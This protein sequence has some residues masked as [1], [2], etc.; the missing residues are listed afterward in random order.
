MKQKGFTVWFTG[1]SDA[2]KSTL[3][4]MLSQRLL[5]RGLK[6]QLLDGGVI[7]ATLN[8]HLEFT[9]EDRDTNVRC[10]GS[11]C[12]A[13]SKNGTVAIA[14]AVSP[15]RATRD[16]LRAKIENLVEVYVKCPLEVLMERDKKGLYQK[17]L[18]GEIKNL[19]GLD[20]PYEE[21]LKPEVI[22]ETHKETPEESI[23]KILK[24]LECLNYIP[25]ESTSPMV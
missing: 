21:P 6:A 7:R 25:A 13:L 2:G 11:M 15:Y 14:A 19:A 12:E 22:V 8:K 20:D 23:Q 17:A 10:I 5:E 4:H 9:K 18:K 24:T 3:S 16:E 1:L